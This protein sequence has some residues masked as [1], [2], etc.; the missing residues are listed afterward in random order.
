MGRVGEWESG[1]EGEQGSRG[2]GELIII[3]YSRFPTPDSRLP[4]PDST[5]T[6]LSGH[7]LPTPDSRRTFS[8]LNLNRGGRRVSGGLGGEGLAEFGIKAI[9]PSKERRVG[10]IIRQLRNPF[11]FQV[12]RDI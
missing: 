2:E 11:P 12:F 8:L 4:T 9:A 5:S 6:S 10:T 1:R 7:R 3:N